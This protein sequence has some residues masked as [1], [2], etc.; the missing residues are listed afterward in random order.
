MI[1]VSLGVFL[2][3]LPMKETYKPVILKRRAKKL[4][5]TPPKGPEGAMKRT[6][7]VNLFRPVHML[8]TEVHI[9]QA[10]L[11]YSLRPSIQAYNR[12]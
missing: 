7:V 4:G 3:A 10:L 6:I 2:S 5:L 12:R 1:F 9:T 11:A 8:L